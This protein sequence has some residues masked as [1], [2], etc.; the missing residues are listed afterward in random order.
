MASEPNLRA[1]PEALPPHAKKKARG[2]GASLSPANGNQ[3]AW[4][5]LQARN[6]LARSAGPLASSTLPGGRWIQAAYVITDLSCITLTFAVVLVARYLPT[7]RGYPT[8]RAATVLTAVIPKHYVGILLLY[9]ALIVLFSRMY[10][11][12]HT[13]RDRSKLQETALVAKALSWSTAMLM[14]TIYL[15]G[16][17]TISRL[18]ILASAAM[19]I[20][21][22]A[23]WRMW[24]RVIVE[25]RVAAGVGVRDVL[26][27]G[28]GKI[29]REIAK[30]FDTNR[31]LGVVV[32]GFLDDNHVEDPRVLGRIEHLVEICRAHFVDEVI[33]TIP[34]VRSRVRR[35]LSQARQHN[36]D[37][38]LVPDL[39][40][41]FTRG[42]TL[43]HLGRVPVMSLRKRSLPVSGRVVKRAMDIIGSVIGLAL[44]SPFIVA[45]A[46]AIWLD[47]PGPVFYRGRRAG[48]KGRQFV[49]YKFRTMVENADALKESVS[50]LNEREGATFKIDDDPRITRV[51]RFLRKYSLDELPQLWNVLKGDMS[52]VGPRPHPLDDYQKY[53]LEHL[54]RLDVTPGLTG[55]WQVTARRDPSFEN[56]VAFDLEYIENW[57]LWLD[58]RILLRTISVVVVGTGS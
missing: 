2:T 3:Q 8:S 25:R 58:L 57:N 29:G 27:V 50:H 22:L 33:I 43:E 12:Y 9:S 26:V 6:P 48:R 21:V 39:Y 24:K 5:N 41:S 51:G 47:T 14:A 35:V 7:W 16:A 52:L 53:D 55:L 31:H 40:G 36:L 4:T 54:R 10:G 56:N 13:P 44:F 1:L 19:N 34:S 15:S 17:K 37:V 45:I 30:Y 38:K 28:A 18:V 42:A 20:V 11:L 46:V 49:C 32:K 23:A